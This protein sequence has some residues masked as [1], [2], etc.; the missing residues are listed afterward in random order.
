MTISVLGTGNMGSALVRTLRDRGVAVSIWNRTR[1]KAEALAGPGV[2]VAETANRALDANA[3][4]LWNL[5]NYEAAGPLLPEDLSGKGLVQLTTGKPEEARRFAQRVKERGGD[6]LDG[7]IMGFPNYVGTPQLTVFYSGS[8]DLFDEHREALDFLGN[9]IFLEEDP[10]AASAFDIGCL[11]P[12]VAMTVGL[13]QGM[14]VCER[15]GIP[16]AQYDEF[17]RAGFPLAIDDTLSKARKKGFAEDPSQ[18][19]CSI[20]LM[21]GLSRLFA[22]YCGD[23]DLDPALLEG[24]ERLFSAGVKSGH[25]AYD[26]TYA[27][28]I[29]ADR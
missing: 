22:D 17:I 18:A 23:V 21:A 20:A 24:L 28:R 10:G 3:C 14:R 29:A 15:E 26:W 16:A 9:S 12:L 6:C 13:L 25:G 4:S 27:P 2:V 11:M 19:E 8:R 1:A 7:A 5:S